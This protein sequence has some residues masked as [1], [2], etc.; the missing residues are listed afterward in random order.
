MRIKTQYDMRI[1]FTVLAATAAIQ[2][3]PPTT[4]N[5][6]DYP[7]PRQS[8]EP[9]PEFLSEMFRWRPMLAAMDCAN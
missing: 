7:Q 5:P 9:P 4:R 3:T 1:M 8:R 6:A 2:A